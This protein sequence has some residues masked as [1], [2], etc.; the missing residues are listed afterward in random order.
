MGNPP[1]PNHPALGRLDRVYDE[2]EGAQPYT[3]REQPGGGGQNSRS[4]DANE[5]GGGSTGGG[6]GGGGGGGSNASNYRDLDI[7]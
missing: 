5:G 6:G 2:Y 3:G 1:D 4:G 7:D